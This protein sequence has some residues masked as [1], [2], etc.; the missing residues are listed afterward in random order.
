M[1]ECLDCGTPMEDIIW[2]KHHGKCKD[3]R[4]DPVFTDDEKL[5]IVTSYLTGTSETQ[6]EVCKRIGITVNTFSQWLKKIKTV[7][8]APDAQED[9]QAEKPRKVFTKDQRLAILNG[10]DK[11]EHQNIGKY[12]DSI[13]IHHA[14]FYNWK[15]KYSDEV[16]QP[17]QPESVTTHFDNIDEL[18]AQLADMK[19][20]IDLSSL[21]DKMGMWRTR[22]DNLKV[23]EKPAQYAAK[24]LARCLDDME[25]ELKQLEVSE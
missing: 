18:I 25:N 5:K 13:G 24:I 11:D 14:T 1:I 4:V 3:C 23:G 8:R 7:K 22:V 2:E 6:E 10:Y 19:P 20:G 21:I 9:A 16:D 17:K 12:C 15:S